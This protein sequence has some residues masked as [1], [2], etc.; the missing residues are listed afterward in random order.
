[1]LYEAQNKDP[2]LL[3]FGFL[4]ILADR[5]QQSPTQLLPWWAIATWNDTDLEDI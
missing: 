2:L 4:Q 5:T 1:M 3:L